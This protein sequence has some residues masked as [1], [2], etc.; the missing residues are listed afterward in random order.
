ML[1]RTRRTTHQLGRRQRSRRL[2]GVRPA[3]PPDRFE[4]AGSGVDTTC[5]RPRDITSARVHLGAPLSSSAR[6]GKRMKH[7]GRVGPRQPWSWRW[8]RSCRRPSA[9]QSPKRLSISRRPR[10]S[11]AAG[12]VALDL[13]KQAEEQHTDPQ[14]DSGKQVGEGPDREERRQRDQRDQCDECDECDECDQRD[15]RRD[16]ATAVTADSAPPFAYAH[17]DSAGNLDPS[18]T[19]NLTTTK[20]GVPRCLSG[21]PG[22]QERHD[23]GGEHFR[24]LRLCL[25]GSRANSQRLSCRH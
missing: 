6:G 5:V 11:A 25:R 19:R 13:G 15:E 17:I 16:A 9:R 22:A 14:A 1:T 4:G 24:P 2:R 10:R 3:V 8:S 7:Y 23:R 21:R 18:R 20:P 12:S